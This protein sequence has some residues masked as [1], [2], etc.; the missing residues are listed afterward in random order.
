M[1]ELLE[2]DDRTLISNLKKVLGTENNCLADFLHY[3]GEVDHRRLYADEGYPSLF[4][5]C[6][7]VLALKEGEA[8][9][10]IRAARFARRFPVVLDLVRNGALCLTAMRIIGPCVDEATEAS[11]FARIAGKTTR[12]IEKIAAEL[13]Q[14]RSVAIPNCQVQLKPMFLESGAPE[15]GKTPA[16]AKPDKVRYLSPELVE[17]RFS[18]TEEFSEKLD[19][20]K[21]IHRAKG[22]SGTA[23]DLFTE[24]LEIYLNRH[25]PKRRAATKRPP[26]VAGA[27][28]SVNPRRPPQAVRDAVALRDRY[29]C[30][31]VAVDGHR[32]LAR[33]GLQYDHVRPFAL[34]GSSLDPD[35]GRL[36]CPAH[37]RL[38]AEHTF[39]RNQIA[40]V[41]Q[42]N[43][44]LL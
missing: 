43:R 5:Y 35:E 39:G 11:L 3:L 28:P 15:S 34:G 2:I 38:A 31:F 44:R 17:V 9:N 20:A 21:R 12:E 19:E 37:N 26:K 6:V 16:N 24:M 36:L 42:R 32:C 23:A 33:T 4:E 8:F 22:Y 14:K 40:A 10:R 41:I 29:Q 18:A 27:I 7:K 1:H 13:S 25:D 30:T